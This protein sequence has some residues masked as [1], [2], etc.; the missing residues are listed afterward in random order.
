MVGVYTN[1]STGIGTVGII[2][3]TKNRPLL[4]V[5]ALQSVLNQKY[6]NWRL[7]LVNDVGDEKIFKDSLKDFWPV[8]KDQTRVLHRLASTGM[9]SASNHALQYAKSE[10][11]YLVIHD[12]DD[13]WH[14]SFLE[15]TVS[16]LKK[17]PDYAG[18]VTQV[19]LVHERI[20]KTLVHEEHRMPGFV[21]PD[22]IRLGDMISTNM[23]PPI[24]FL[25]RMSVVNRI[26]QFNEKLP[27]LG[28]WDYALRVLMQGDIGVIPKML[29]YYHHRKEAT[30]QYSNTV[31]EGRDKHEHYTDLLVNASLRTLLKAQPGYMGLIH[32]MQRRMRKQEEL[33]AATEDRLNE[34]L[35]TL[36]KEL[37]SNNY[38]LRRIGYELEYMNTPWYKR[39]F[40]RRREIAQTD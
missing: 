16:F 17:N 19:Q 2:M 22:R 38:A 24:C 25:I 39:I 4:L 8:L 3:R 5:R 27:V 11:E 14:P 18:T 37:L 34:Q 20:R 40:K 13:S 9:E 6:T 33:W 31:I 30:D 21:P 28:D 15:E 10:C 36:K 26:G 12:D 7:Y 32:L 35:E 1:S 29:A 23:F